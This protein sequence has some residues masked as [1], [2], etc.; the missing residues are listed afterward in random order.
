MTNLPDEHHV[1]RYVPW[2]KLRKDEDDNVVGVLFSAF[3]LR[4]G[5][6]LSPAEEYLSVNWLEY[7]RDTETRLRDTIH[8]IRKTRVCGAKSAFVS[9][10][11]RKIKDAGLA[12]GHRIRI[13]HEREDDN[14]GHSGIRRLPADD[15]SL[16]TALAEDVF[17]ELTLNSDVPSNES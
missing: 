12:S 14:P 3:Q 10:N 5:S 16:L 15:I 9:G 7:E 11:V 1:V 13:V 4:P 17:S 8:A 2:S 6:E